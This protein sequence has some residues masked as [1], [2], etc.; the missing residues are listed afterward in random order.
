M[1]VAL[2]SVLQAARHP[3]QRRRLESIELRRS[4]DVFDAHPMLLNVKNGHAL[5]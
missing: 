2:D 5:L 1:S 3:A 4:S